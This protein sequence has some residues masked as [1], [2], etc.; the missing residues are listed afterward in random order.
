MK[1]APYLGKI[2][3]FWH[4]DYNIPLIGKKEKEN[5]YEVNLTPPGDVRPAFKKDIHLIKKSVDKLING[6]SSFFNYPILIN[7]IPELD[8]MDEVITDGFIVGKIR[9]NS[10]SWDFDFF[11]SQSGAKVLLGFILNKYNNPDKAIKRTRHVIVD[12]SAAEKIAMGKNILAPGIIYST[13]FKKGDYVY[14]NESKHYIYLWI[15]SF[16]KFK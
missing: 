1:K 5:V 6:A 3:L 8:K 15:F 13:E 7:N 16:T 12:S 10:D 11:P 4:K 14:L 2:K 9:F